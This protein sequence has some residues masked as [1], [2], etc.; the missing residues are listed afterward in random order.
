MALFLFIIVVRRGQRQEAEAERAE[1]IREHQ[2]HV[3]Q[4]T[5]QT[6]SA[7][8]AMRMDFEQRIAAA[9]DNHREAMQ[10]VEAE[11]VQRISKSYIESR[12]DAMRMGLALHDSW[13]MYSGIR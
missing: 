4:L 1:L 5:K 6:N 11:C 2:Q 9:A 10:R 13:Q 3:E 8:H 7:L 12:S